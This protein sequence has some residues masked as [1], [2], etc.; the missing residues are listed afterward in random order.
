MLVCF[1][2]P[3]HV[4]LRTLYHWIQILNEIDHNSPNSEAVTGN[5]F[6]VSFIVFIF[7]LLRA[8]GGLIIKGDALLLSK[9]HLFTSSLLSLSHHCSI[10][11]LSRE[12]PQ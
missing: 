2:L 12:R 6:I 10:I 1:G 8:H 3:V 4:I 11:S 9:I 7:L 5:L